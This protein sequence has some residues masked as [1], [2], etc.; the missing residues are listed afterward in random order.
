MVFEIFITMNETYF[1]PL[2][3]Y[4]LYKVNILLLIYHISVKIVISFS[5]KK[6]KKVSVPHLTMKWNESSKTAF[7]HKS[8]AQ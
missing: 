8:V 5:V 7:L 2:N 1:T 3:D 4:T 6:K